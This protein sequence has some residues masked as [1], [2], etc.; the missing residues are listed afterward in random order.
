MHVK[1]IE[2]RA[3][4]SMLATFDGIDPKRV[5]AAL[6]VLK[7]KPAAAA[8]ALADVGQVFKAGAVAKLLSVTTRTVR[9]LR[10]KGLLR[11][12]RAPGSSRCLGYSASSV[13]AF[14]DGRSE[15]PSAAV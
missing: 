3:L 2:E 11:E 15:A 7:G 10:D 12:V 5:D 13:R 9:N 8:P 1:E 6:Q 4:R 14:I